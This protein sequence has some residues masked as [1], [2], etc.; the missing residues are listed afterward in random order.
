MHGQQHMMET[1]LSASCN[2]WRTATRRSYGT[3]ETISLSEQGSQSFMYKAAHTTPNKSYCMRTLHLKAPSRYIR[4][5]SSG[6]ALQKPNL[7]QK[8]REFASSTT[9]LAS[10]P[11]S[12]GLPVD[13]PPARRM[14]LE[15]T[16]LSHR[17]E[18]RIPRSPGPLTLA[19]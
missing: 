15:A 13:R 5:S 6:T 7:V 3:G 4:L 14:E 1:P 12:I 8:E 11:L 2:I 19:V 16:S 10:F 17:R 18:G 9:H